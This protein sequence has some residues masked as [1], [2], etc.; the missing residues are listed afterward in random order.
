MKDA[1]S[2]GYEVLG[3]D[4]PTH[5]PTNPHRLADVFNIILSHKVGWP[6]HVEVIYDMDTQHLSI[7]ITVGIGGTALVTANHEATYRLGGISDVSGNA[8]PGILICD[9]S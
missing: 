6:V 4:T 7:L 1:K 3:P 2:Q 9:R 8:A 5:V